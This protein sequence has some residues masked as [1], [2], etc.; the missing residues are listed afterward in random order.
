MLIFKVLDSSV[1]DKVEPL[2]FVFCVQIQNKMTEKVNSKCS[3]GEL[4]QT[5]CNELHFSRSVGLKDVGQLDS[6]SRDVLLWRAG[7]REHENLVKTICFHHE[8]FFGNVFERRQ[9]KCCAVLKTHKKRAQGTRR[10]TLEIANRLQ[11]K[12]HEI[13]P[14][15]M[16][17]RQCDKCYQDLC[18]KSSEL[19]SP[20]EMDDDEDAPDDATYEHFETPR[21]RLNTTLGMVGVSPVNLHSVPQHSR[22][23]SA[24]QKLEKVIDVYKSSLAEAYNVKE[25]DICDNSD[26][27]IDDSDIQFKSAELDRLHDLMREKLKIVP[28]PRKIQILTLVPDKWSRELAAKQFG[29]S[30]YLIRTARDLK[31]V[32]GI[33][34]MPEPKRGKSLSKETLDKVRQFYEDDEYSRQMPGKKDCVSVGGTQYQKRLVLCNLSELYAAFKEA[35]PNVKI[36]F[37]KFCS[38]RPKWCVLAGASGTHSVCVCSMHQNAVLLTDAVDWDFTYKDLMEKVVCDVES[39]VC[40]MHRC[41]SCPGSEALEKFLDDELRHLDMDSEFHYCQWQTTDRASLVTLTTTYGEYKDLLV[42]K[43]N[44]LTRHSYLA[45]AQA[46]YIKAKKESLKKNEVMI[47][48]DFAEN[49]QFLIQDE[50]Q[51]FHWSKEYC[52]LHPL[53]IYYKDDEGNLQHHSLCFI[54]DDNTHDTCFVHQIQTMIFKFIKE[55]IPGITKIYYVSDGCGGQYKNY[56][57]FLNL[58]YHKDDYGIDAE[59]IFFATS[60]G[61]SPCDGIQDSVKRHAAKRNLQRLKNNEI[62]DY[63]AVLEVCQAEMKSIVFFG[64][65]KE[66]MVVVRERMEKRFEVGKTIPGTR[67]SHHFIPQ[68][69]AKIAHKLCSEDEFFAATHDFKIPCHVLL[70]DVT[71]STYVTCVYNSFWWV[72]LVHKVNQDQ[73]DVDIQFMHPHGPRKTFNWPRR[74][75]QCPVPITNIICGIQVPKTH[76]TGRNFTISDKDYNKTVT[77]YAALH[78]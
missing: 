65:D 27:M 44:E 77:S 14:G 33:L 8:Q 10:V 54:S 56:K 59:R 28:Y 70:S 3:F 50:K 67:S 29:V 6:D 73:G 74:T 30:E 42:E 4:L 69:G 48:G 37:S 47:L 11:A 62:L 68:G 57:N 40:M 75:D 2:I 16:L 72:G 46:K 71:P 53:V 20:E 26:T 60:H 12:G 66:D 21:K 45:K 64:I 52:T 78:M 55:K 15:M 41:E 18:E 63:K 22:T 34:A 7:L 17:C 38:L 36:G 9:E 58:C 35:H 5:P 1:G 23:G 43:I 76:S 39:R 24:K 13:T 31:K 25:D 61:K 32:G 19:S 49:Y 51:S